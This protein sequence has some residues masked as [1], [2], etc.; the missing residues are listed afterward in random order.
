MN[1]RYFLILLLTLT[2]ASTALADRSALEA[3]K[4]RKAEARAEA[5][6]KA[7]AEAEEPL[8]YEPGKGLRK[9]SEVEPRDDPEDEDEVEPLPTKEWLTSP[10]RTQKQ[11]QSIMKAVIYVKKLCD[12]DNVFQKFPECRESTHCATVKGKEVYFYTFK[13]TGDLKDAHCMINFSRKKGGTPESVQQSLGK[14]SAVDPKTNTLWYCNYPF[15]DRE[16]GFRLEEIGCV[17]YVYKNGQQIG[18]SFSMMETEVAKKGDR[19]GWCSQSAAPEDDPTYCDDTWS[20]E[21]G[22]GVE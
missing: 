17:G 19:E 12:F 2:C 11:F 4:R 5:I 22:W 15:P 6:V 16:R 18:N 20:P 10:K 21:D 14:P 9:Q 13:K 3:A 8:V 1:I 7:R